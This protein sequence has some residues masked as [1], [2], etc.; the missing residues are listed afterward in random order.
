MEEFGVSG[1]VFS[2][3]SF[4]G[5]PV[6]EP[7]VSSDVIRGY[8]SANF[9]GSTPGSSAGKILAVTFIGVRPLSCICGRDS[10]FLG[11]ALFPGVG[12]PFCKN[13]LG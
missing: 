1:G 8:F 7:P 2:V 9:Y 10:T 6:G 11:N 13:G 4:C 3:A 12:G 5:Q